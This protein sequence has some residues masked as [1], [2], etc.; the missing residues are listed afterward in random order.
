MPEIKDQTTGFL[1][2]YSCESWT[3]T[4]A[5]QRRTQALEMRFN[6]II[7]GIFLVE[8]IENDIVH[9]TIK[10]KTGILEVFLT[11]FKRRNL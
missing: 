1:F 6:R 2:L 9:A 5:F 7:P 11:T 3:L 4:A 10:Q 8:R